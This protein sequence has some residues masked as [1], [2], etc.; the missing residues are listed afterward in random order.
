MCVFDCVRYASRALCFLC[1]SANLSPSLS[2]VD[3]AHDHFEVCFGEW[4]VLR[5][6]MLALLYEQRV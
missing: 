3:A 6:Y 2:C 1:E 4:Y 5:N